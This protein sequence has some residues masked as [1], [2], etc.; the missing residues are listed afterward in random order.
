MRLSTR[1]MLNKD[2][3]RKGTATSNNLLIMDIQLTSWSR[4][5][6]KKLLDIQL[7][8]K[9]SNFMEPVVSLPYSYKPAI[10][11][12]ILSK[13]SQFYNPI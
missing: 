10:V 1:K 5:L 9:M 4:I 8:K 2:Q 13:F 6:F 7:V 11:V 12:L 3:Y